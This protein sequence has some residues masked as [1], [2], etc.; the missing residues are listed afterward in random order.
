MDTAGDNHIK[1]TSHGETCLH[2]FVDRSHSSKWDALSG[3]RGCCAYSYDDFMCHCGEIPSM[4]GAPLSQRRTGR[5][6]FVRVEPGGGG[7]KLG[8][9]VTK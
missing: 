7:L 3:S 5:R 2:S 1:L 9:K 8:C 6:S 4:G